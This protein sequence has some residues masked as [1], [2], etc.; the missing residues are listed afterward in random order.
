MLEVFS[1]CAD[2]PLR[3]LVAGHDEPAPFLAHAE[4]LRIADRVQFFGPAADVRFFYAAA[5]VLAAPSLEDSFNLP[6]LEAM[7]CGLP[8]V[9]SARTG[10]SDWLTS[11]QDS[12]VLQDPENAQELRSAIRTLALDPALRGALAE[13]ALQT[14]KKF[15]WDTHAGE[16]RKLLVKAAEIKSRRK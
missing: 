2:L 4:K 5:D 7:S 8:V 9:V 13:N 10:I 1:Q 16:L 15:S 14:A 12:L 6:V 3:L 11:A